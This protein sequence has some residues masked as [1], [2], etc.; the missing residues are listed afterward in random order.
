MWET[1]LPIP[2]LPTGGR[3]LCAGYCQLRRRAKGRRYA[4]ADGMDHRPTNRLEGWTAARQST[5]PL[6]ITP[7]EDTQ[8]PM[9]SARSESR[10]NQN[11][12]API[13]H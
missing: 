5:H 1:D 13:M 7:F 12:N 4:D 10:H 8:L 2:S 6:I 9:N 3:P 11:A